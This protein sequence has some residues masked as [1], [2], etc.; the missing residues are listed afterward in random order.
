MSQHT[1]KPLSG[2]RQAQANLFGCNNKTL[3]WQLVDRHVGLDCDPQNPR[4]S[5]FKYYR[6]DPLTGR[7][8]LRRNYMRRLVNPD[9]RRPMVPYMRW[10]IEQRR[11]MQRG[12]ALDDARQLGARWKSLPSEDKQPYIEAYKA[13]RDRYQRAVA[14]HRR[15]H[16]VNAPFAEIVPRPKSEKK[17]G[18]YEWYKRRYPVLK[19]QIEAQGGKWRDIRVA[20]KKEWDEIKNNPRGGT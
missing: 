3:K 18:Y 15:V 13:D 11:Q 5:N 12:Y 16:G 8:K 9:L 19:N 7:Y 14:E 10:E 6:C 20:I 17:A 2:K 1:C 4:A